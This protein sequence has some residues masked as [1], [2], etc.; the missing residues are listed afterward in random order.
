MK[1][2]QAKQLKPGQVIYAIP[3]SGAFNN[4]GKNADGSLMRFKV[5]SVKTWKRNLDKVLIG[6]KRGLYEYYKINENEIS[7]FSIK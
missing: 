4:S 7:Q 5:T 1:V 2:T 3:K 6:I